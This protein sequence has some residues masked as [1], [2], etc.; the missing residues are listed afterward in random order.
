MLHLP[1]PHV[2]QLTQNLVRPRWHKADSAALKEGKAQGPA[3]S[4]VVTVELHVRRDLEDDEVLRLTRWAWER[5]MQALHFGS[6]TGDGGM[7]E[8]EVTVGIVRG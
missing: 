4:L 8:A 7:A 6:G 1:A 3:Q 5:C 2:W